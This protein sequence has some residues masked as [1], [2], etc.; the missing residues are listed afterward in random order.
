MP[1]SELVNI[2]IN[3]D[4]IRE[5]ARSLPIK[6]VYI[7]SDW[8][9][10]ETAIVVV[11]R[12]HNTGNVTNGIYY[13]D[14]Y[15][16]GLYCT[17]YQYNVNLPNIEMVLDPESRWISI[18]Y[19]EA[20]ALIY[21]AIEY[22]QNLSIAPD[23]D[24]EITQFL[25][26]EREAV[27]TPCKREF[28]YYGF[29]FLI[30]E[31][32]K[33]ASKY[34]PFLEKHVGPEFKIEIRVPSPEIEKER[35]EIMEEQRNKML[36]FA[37]SIAPELFTEDDS[38]DEDTEELGYENR[39]GEYS[40]IPPDY[41]TKLNLTHSELE[42]LYSPQYR[43]ILTDKK[44]DHILA[45]PHDSLINDLIRM[46]YVELGNTAGWQAKMLW[47]PDYISPLKHIVL[48]LGELQAEQ[49]LEVL[50]EML[51][52]SFGFLNFHYGS[53]SAAEK[54][55]PL[56]I[57]L[58]GRNQLPVIRDFVREPGL[59]PYMRICAF[60]GVAHIFLHEEDRRD[61]IIHW[62][63][64][65]LHFLL[66]NSEN[67]SIYDSGLIAQI[68]CALAD[69]KASELLPDLKAFYDMKIVDESYSG[70]FEDILEFMESEDPINEYPLLNIYERYEYLS[71]HRYG[72]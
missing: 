11:T 70:P 66:S 5:S 57:Y 3:D 30:V 19:E 6:C 71:K 29:P 7:T 34:L 43:K 33:E 62:F 64:E 4:Y 36:C 26:K 46:L 9:T 54:I 16:R 31:S 20:H 15:C 38:E 40:Y 21:G 22:A 12:Q 50:L 68:A 41:P 18:S 60:I 8:E 65:Q 17:H 28:G 72:Y 67:P 23:E 45:L 63:R 52:Q 13:L 32:E 24:F 58:V 51:R 44:I 37:R 14:M 10:A 25:L 47:N 61:E 2:F 53:Y 39:Q 59:E 27:S 48:L 55:I 69:V 49:S 42:A 1:L 35:E 56:S